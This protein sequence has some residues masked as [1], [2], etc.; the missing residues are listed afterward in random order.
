MILP[1]DRNSWSSL[2]WYL[3]P[4]GEGPGKKKEKIKKQKTHTNGLLRVLIRP[5][6]GAYPL[7]LVEV[8]LANKPSED[9]QGL[10]VSVLASLGA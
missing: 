3:D 9:Y 6:W 1:G 10:F 4:K 2:C 5:S 8:R 7:L